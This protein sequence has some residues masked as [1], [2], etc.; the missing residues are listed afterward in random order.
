MKVDYEDQVNI[1]IKVLNKSM[2]D[3]VAAGNTFAA[4]VVQN[5]IN[6]VKEQSD[7]RK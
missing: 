3:Y 4:Y 6:K 5:I 7:D 2:N 1:T